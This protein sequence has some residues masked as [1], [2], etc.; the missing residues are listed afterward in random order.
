MKH[1]VYATVYICMELEQDSNS[2]NEQEELYNE[3][4]TLKQDIYNKGEIK[5]TDRCKVLNVYVSN[6][7]VEK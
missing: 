5:I 3:I 4:E 1:K 6:W 7:E 2:N